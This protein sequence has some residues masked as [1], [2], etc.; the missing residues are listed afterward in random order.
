MSVSALA[1]A[2][3]LAYE[4]SLARLV[5][6]SIVESTPHLGRPPSRGFV[7]AVL[8]G[9][10]REDVVSSDAHRLATFGVLAGHGL[11]EARSL[12]DKVIAG[13]LAETLRSRA[14]IV[15]TALGR[16]TLEGRLT[17]HDAGRS[18]GI[19]KG[20]VNSARLDVAVRAGLVDALRRYRAE[21]AHAEEAPEH[22]VFSEATLRE[23]A[24][25]R[26]TTEAALLSTP[27]L[28]ARRGEAHG[29]EL[30]RI[31]AEHEPVIARLEA[32]CAVRS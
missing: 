12:V 8:T 25:A 9:S 2:T 10:L 1:S 19:V 7:A 27:G 30:L 24:A 32:A 5:L 29:A 20:A 23:I 22:R 17:A 3:L 21:I 28:G 11:T 16:A 26:P 4:A 15:C 13:G 31:V 14:A 18:L 6:L